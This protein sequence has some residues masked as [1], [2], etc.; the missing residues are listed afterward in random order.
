MKKNLIVQVVVCH[1]LIYEAENGIPQ[2]SVVTPI[3]FNIIINY[4]FDNFWGLFG[5][6]E[7]IQSK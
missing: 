5:R 6:E 4:I 7:K 3:L 2:G 1:S